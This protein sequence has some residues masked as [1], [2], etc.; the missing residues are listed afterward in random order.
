MSPRD[1]RFLVDTIV[2][3]SLYYVN[4]RDGIDCSILDYRFRDLLIFWL[5][6]RLADSTR[7]NWL[8]FVDFAS[9]HIDLLHD[10]ADRGGW[11]VQE[12]GVVHEGGGICVVLL[13]DL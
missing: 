7:P 12:H 8:D 13:E 1:S 4:S 9:C 3:V 10:T 11:L 6:I 5:I 2:I